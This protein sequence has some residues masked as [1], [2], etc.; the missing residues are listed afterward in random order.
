MPQIWL[1]SDTHFGHELLSTIR[2]FDSVEQHDAAIVRTWNKQIRAEDTVYHVGDVF[3]GQPTIDL[4]ELNGTIHLITGNHDK[5]HPGHRV[6]DAER[7]TEYL[8]VF[9]TIQQ[10]A[11]IRYK[12]TEFIVSHY[13][14]DGE[15]RDQQDRDTQWRLHDLGRPLIHGHTHSTEKYSESL[16]GTP[17]LHV[18]WDAWR[19]PVRVHEVIEL[20]A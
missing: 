6:P 15:G 16:R 11:R 2:G 18:G 4:S 8:R 1:T 5:V 17:Q 3:L 20:L 7:F 14:Y 10:F 9:A 13:P 12:G 19:R